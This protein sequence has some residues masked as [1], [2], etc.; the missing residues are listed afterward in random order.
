MKTSGF[1][2]LYF[3]LVQLFAGD[4]LDLFC[5]PSPTPQGSQDCFTYG[6]CQDPCGTPSN[7]TVLSNYRC[8]CDS[9]CH[10]YRD[11]CPELENCPLSLPSHVAQQE[12]HPRASV[13]AMVNPSYY[14][15]KE[16]G[17]EQLSN[18]CLSAAKQSHTKIY[19]QDVNI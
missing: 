18:L 15:R 5:L 7:A 16:D 4:S 14:C 3:L 2:F 10:L 9:L 11:C 19:S 13:K 8:G 1:S 17:H 12:Q 6:P